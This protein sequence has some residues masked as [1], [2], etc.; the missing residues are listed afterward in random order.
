[1]ISANISDCKGVSMAKLNQDTL[2]YSKD[3]TVFHIHLV[4]SLRYL[5]V[6]SFQFCLSHWL[7]EFRSSRPETMKITA[8]WY[9]TPCSLIEIY[10]TSHPATYVQHELLAR[11]LYNRHTQVANLFVYLG[12]ITCA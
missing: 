6:H 9:V 2:A 12:I 4:G 7:W 11:D 8:A 5:P 1:M 10:Q 3:V